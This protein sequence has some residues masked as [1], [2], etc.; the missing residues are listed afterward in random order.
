MRTK[1]D[2]ALCLRCKYHGTGG[3]RSVTAP[4]DILCD[5]A[6]TSEEKRPCL[7]VVHGE[8][9]DRRGDKYHECLLFEEGEPLGRAKN[10]ISVTEKKMHRTVKDKRR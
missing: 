8:V 9:I 5:Y 4:N 3:A 6:A 1:H 7:T 2:K 10:A